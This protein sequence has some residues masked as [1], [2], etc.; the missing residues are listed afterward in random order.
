[1]SKI[2]KNVMSLKRFILRSDSLKLYRDLL[3]AIKK[4]PGKD[5]QSELRCWVR[6]DFERNKHHENEDVIKYHI[7]RGK[8]F[9]GKLLRNINLSKG[10]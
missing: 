8:S 4:I 9:C 2:N 7:A 3:R 5:Y 10:S 1:M 6:E